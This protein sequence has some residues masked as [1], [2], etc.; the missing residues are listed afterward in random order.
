YVHETEFLEILSYADAFEFHTTDGA[1]TLQ[2]LTHMGR[3]VF[4]EEGVSAEPEPPDCATRLLLRPDNADWRIDARRSIILCSVHLSPNPSTIWCDKGGQALRTS[5]STS[6]AQ[7]R[8][9][10]SASRRRR[11]PGRSRPMTPRDNWMLTIFTEKH[12]ARSS[13][14]SWAPKAAP[15]ISG[16]NGGASTAQTCSFFASLRLTAS[17]PSSAIRSALASMRSKQHSPTS[18]IRSTSRPTRYAIVF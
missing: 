3:V 5:C 12:R 9:M 18:H 10:R 16:G 1:C 8:T 11:R 14:R 17:A 4:G 6:A 7:R 15:S 2:C 13:V